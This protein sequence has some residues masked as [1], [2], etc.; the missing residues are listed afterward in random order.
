MTFAHVP[1]SAAWKHQGARTGF[2]VA[3][4][5]LVHDAWHIGG[6]TTAVEEGK[7]WVVEYS[8]RLDA[9]WTTRR[10]HITARSGSGRRSTLLETDGAGSWL[11]DGQ[12]RPDLDDCLDVDLE[13]SAMTNALPAHRMRLPVGAEANAPAAYV[14]ALDLRVQRLEQVYLRVPDEGSH[15]A[16]DYSAAEFAFSCRLTYDASGLVLSYPGIAVRAA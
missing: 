9:N 1:S 3:Y 5:N 6:A 2:E 11:V 8:L 14:R 4:F 13:S 10:A 16:Y 7:T 12:A 15:E